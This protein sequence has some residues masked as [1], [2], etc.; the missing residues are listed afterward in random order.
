MVPGQ[1]RVSEIFFQSQNLEGLL[2]ESRNL[3][4]SCF[5]ASWILEFLVSECGIFVFSQQFRSNP[6]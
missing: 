2:T 3:V 5:F 1:I 6:C 4:L